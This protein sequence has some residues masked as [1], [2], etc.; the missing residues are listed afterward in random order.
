MY[1]PKNAV[2]RERDLTPTPAD[3]RHA[4]STA[5]SIDTVLL[6]GGVIALAILLGGLFKVL[7]PRD[8]G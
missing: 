5:D 6:F 3:T 4:P 2:P 7:Q 1:Y 8:N